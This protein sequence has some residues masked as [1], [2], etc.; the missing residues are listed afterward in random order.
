MKIKSLFSLFI[1]ATLVCSQTSEASET[2]LK[3]LET[4]CQK[5][6]KW[7]ADGKID[8]ILALFHADLLKYPASVKMTSKQNKKRGNDAKNR[9][10]IK[11]FESVKGSY[12]EFDRSKLHSSFKQIE[13]EVRVKV[14]ISYNEAKIIRGA[15]CLFGKE[16][17]KERWIMME[18]F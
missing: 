7:Q 5:A 13:K 16:F 8:K 18:T 2:E 4:L 15:S 1:F 14:K 9:G 10:G 12:V 3:K 17:N 11:A 6:L